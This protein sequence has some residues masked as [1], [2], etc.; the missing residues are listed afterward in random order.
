M[1]PLLHASDL[2]LTLTWHA[3]E[4][5]YLG[6]YFEWPG[7]WLGRFARVDVAL[8]TTLVISVDVQ[9]RIEVLVSRLVGDRR[10]NLI[11]L[12]WSVESVYKQPTLLPCE[13]H[14]EACPHIH[15]QRPRLSELSRHTLTVPA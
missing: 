11:S 13:V 6:P 7:E 10:K 3:K 9:Q 5:E 15:M 2:H 1:H 14:G 12:I 4:P 8:L